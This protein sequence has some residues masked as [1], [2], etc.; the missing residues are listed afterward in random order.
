MVVLRCARE[1]CGPGE[2]TSR[3]VNAAADIAGDGRRYRDVGGRRSRSSD[4][5][6]RAVM[7]ANVA[8]EK[9]LDSARSPIGGE[10]EENDEHGALRRVAS[11]RR[12]RRRGQ[13]GRSRG[14]RVVVASVSVETSDGAPM[15]P[16]ASKAVVRISE[17]ASDFLTE[18][19]SANLRRPRAYSDAN[20][21]ASRTPTERGKETCSSCRRD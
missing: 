1:G 2:R 20:A 12:R 16:R 6:K 14:R 5:A 11:R 21:A 9:S 10:I 18:M 4:S 17:R 7:S 19:S 15:R 8:G 13:R 3:G